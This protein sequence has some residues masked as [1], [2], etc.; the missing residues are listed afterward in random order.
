MDWTDID[1]DIIHEQLIPEINKKFKQILGYDEEGNPPAETQTVA[2]LRSEILTLL[3]NYKVYDQ[4]GFFLGKP[5]AGARVYLFIA[6]RNF[7]I[8]LDFS[9]SQA[10]AIQTAT[11]DAVFT[12]KKNGTSIGTITFQAGISQGLFSTGGAVVGVSAGDKIEIIAPDPQDATLS[13][14]FWNLKISWQ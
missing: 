9:G 5:D 2:E 12:I 6:V 4:A 13:D 14:I 1:L 11:A 8:P 7:T 10:Y 3:E